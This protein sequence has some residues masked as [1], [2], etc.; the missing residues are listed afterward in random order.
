MQINFRQG[1][2]QAPN[3]FLQANGATVNLSIASPALL[4]VAFA[5]GQ[6]NY[7]H[8]ERSTVTSA[9]TGPFTSGP[10]YWLYWD[11]N[12]VSGVR[13]FG[14]TLFEPVEA[15][16]APLSPVNDQHW[17]DTNLN[18]MK[19][20]N[21][22][23]AR[24]VN[25]IR[26]FAGKYQSGTTFIS[27]SINAPD[28][29]GTQ[30]GSLA[31]VPVDAGAL[32]FDLNGDPVKRN[33]GAFFTTSDVVTASVASASR[34]KV[35]AV[36]I[37]A[38]ATSNIPA[39]SIVKFSGFHEVELQTGLMEFASVYGMVEIDA[40]IGDV[41]T[42]VLDG[43]VTNPAWNWTAAGP[44][45]PLYVDPTGVLTPTEPTD[46]VVV[47]AVVDINSILV[48]PTLQTVTSISGSPLAVSDEG[49]VLTTDAFSMNFV[50]P[51]VTATNVG[52]AVTVTVPGNPLTVIDEV[53]SLTAAATSLTFAGA[54]VTASGGP[55]VTVTVPGNPL[56]V[57]EEGSQLTAAA[58]SLNF[59]GANITATNVLGAVTVTV[60][61]GAPAYE[62]FVATGGQTVFNTTL[63]TVAIG[64][65]LSH[66]QVFRNGVFQ[67]EGGS[68]AFT[69][70]GANQITFN[71]G[72]LLNDDVV[73]YAFN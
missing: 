42:V 50:G 36:M 29:T 9:W 46:G 69:V 10:D 35:G 12:P 22:T 13:T 4:L 32:V 59:V 72:V 43:V 15:A 24:W 38:V 53:T 31:A 20:W 27:M 23:A 62:A 1:I 70:T 55:A 30:V 34:V 3:A 64:G 48:R 73:I 71:A 54:G 6:A 60:G 26:V 25:K 21:T 51:G 65:G 66:L 7:L 68:K 33:G 67:Q 11:L 49:S 61:G 40:V 14:H 16:S 47:G 5:D 37:E 39:Y 63:S 2:V 45:A 58:T 56:A 57:S 41:V 52:P 8:T 19:V 44:S 28:F 17:F 18:K